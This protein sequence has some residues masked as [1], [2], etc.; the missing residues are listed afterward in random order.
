MTDISNLSEQNKQLLQE[1]RRRTNQMAAINVVTSAVGQS[2]DLEKTLETALE[3]ALQIVE[4]G[5]A[6]GISLIDEANNELVLRAQRGWVN[7]FVSQNPMRIP[8]HQG[9]SGRVVDSDDVVMENDL[10]HAQDLAVPSF[11]SEPFR[12]IVMAPMHARGRII[13][14]LS[15]MSS[16]PNSFDEDIIPVLRVVADTVGVAIENARLYS[17]T[18]EQKTRLQAILNATVDGII[19]TDHETRITL[20]NQAAELMLGINSRDVLGETLRQAAFPPRVRDALLKALASRAQ[21]ENSMFQVTLDNEHVLAAL[22]SPVSYE[23]SDQYDGWVIVL[24]DIT[25]VRQA[26]IARAQFMQ[27]AAHD[28]RNPLSVTYSSIITLNKI[29]KDKA[30]SVEEII[31]LALNGLAR[32]RGLIDDLLHLEHIESGYNFNAVE[33]NLLDVLH[34]VHR[35]G[36]VLLE[37]KSIAFALEV[38]PDLPLIVGDVRWIKRALHNYLGNAAK[39]TPM[40]GKVLLRVYQ[41]HD[42]IHIEVIDNGPGIPVSAQPQLFDRFYRVEGNKTEGSGLGLAIVKSVAQAHGGSVYV[43]SKPGEGATFGMTLPC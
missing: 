43:Y 10:I 38:Q 41:Q 16:E 8:L 4:N 12:S 21:G 40:G 23:E 13:G 27:A 9:L 37:E 31:S 15:I 24:H 2:L 34:E 33:F 5:E 11:R 28:M 26:E 17:E 30:K 7:D 3:I 22:V 6:S 29:V 18:V 32:L 25:Y 1:I 42:F 14:I 19:V 35:E 20:V 39:Y 36:Y